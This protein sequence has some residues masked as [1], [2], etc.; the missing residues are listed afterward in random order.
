MA[1]RYQANVF[2]AAAVLPLENYSNYAASLTNV[3]RVYA[4]SLDALGSSMSKPL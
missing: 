1:L 2:V 4:S 3:V